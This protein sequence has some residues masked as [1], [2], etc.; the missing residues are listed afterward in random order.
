MNYKVRFVDYPK[1]YQSMKKEVDAAIKEVMSNG[2]FI[3][4]KHLQEFEE[5]M[6]EFLGAKYTVGVNSGTDALFFSLLVSDIGK[7]DEVIT[8][9]HTFVATIAGIVHCGATPVLVDISDDMNMDT[10]LIEELITSKTKAIMPVHL[11]GRMCDMDKIMRIADKHNLSVIEDSAQALGATYKNKMA[12]SFGEA[13]CFSY[14]PAKILGAV[15]DGGLISTNN[16][17]TAIKI[18][19]LRDNGRIPKTDVID[20]FGYNSRLDNIHA[21]IL[22]VKLNHLSSWIQRRREIAMTYHIGLSN[23]TEIILPSPPCRNTL[24]FDVFQNY[25]IRV[26]QRDSLVSYLRNQ[27]IEIIVSWPTPLNK[28]ERLGLQHFSLP[29]TEKISNEVLS[30]PLYPELDNQKI[31]YVIEQIQNFY[32]GDVVENI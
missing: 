10:N 20:G 30:L 23:I 32:R 15:G 11:N 14:Y 18:R 12:G 6:A 25:V 13:N 27:G 3:L 5:N 19:S 31:G 26:K 7:G 2:D 4:R 9:A 21:S 16:E 1:Q 28:Q 29:V 17:W 8:P 22:N 24:Y